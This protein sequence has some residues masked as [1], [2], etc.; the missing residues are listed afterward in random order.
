[1]I[2]CLAHPAI[3]GVKKEPIKNNI[4]NLYL[5]VKLLDVFIQKKYHNKK[6]VN[7]VT[8]KIFVMAL[9]FDAVTYQLLKLLTSL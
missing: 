3:Q 5:L 4:M 9:I 7:Q 1:M 8:L 6:E 2:I